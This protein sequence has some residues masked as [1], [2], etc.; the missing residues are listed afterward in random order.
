MSQPN[1]A[2]I[3]EYD[4][5]DFRGWQLQPGERTVEGVFRSALLELTGDEPTV[6]A[7]GRTDTGVHASHQVVNFSPTGSIPVEN[8][9]LALNTVLPSDVAARRAAIVPSEFH[10]RYSALNRTYRYRVL[11]DAVRTPLHSRYAWRVSDELSVTA[12]RAAAEVF[13]GEH[14]FTAF[15]AA[16]SAGESRVR[17]LH[18]LYVRRCGDTI[19]FELSA[20]GF[21]RRMVRSIVGT[22]VEV[23]RRR[24]VADDVADL[25]ATRS[26]D[27]APAPAPAHGLTLIDVRYP[28]AFG[29]GASD[30]ITALEMVH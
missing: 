27:R 14:D 13:L 30:T 24:L 15:A 25:L 29:V 1:V 3:L 10:A 2:V 9:H 16:D 5:T 8:L 12:M 21:L 7:A 11:E 17:T 20:N 23:G 19:E 6:Y 26:R 4:G 22:L 18:A 28:G